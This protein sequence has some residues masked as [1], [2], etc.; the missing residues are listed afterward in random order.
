MIQKKIKQKIFIIFILITLSACHHKKNIKKNIDWQERSSWSVNG[1]IAIKGGQESGSGRILW[2]VENGTIH[3]Q[4]KAPLGQGSWE[5]TENNQEAILNS[6]KYGKKIGSNAE[7][8]ISQE[9]GW[10]FPWKKLSLWLRGVKNPE[11]LNNLT[12][13]QSQFF[14]QGWH[15]IFDK[16]QETSLGLLPKKITATK[17]P[18]SV[19]L[20]IYGWEAN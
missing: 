17:P 5:I 16:W 4:F 2:Q 10:Q 12:N 6:S 1:K 18:Y 20:I 8:L 14:D 13:K 7:T 3:A 19:K 15:I 11:Q 9:L